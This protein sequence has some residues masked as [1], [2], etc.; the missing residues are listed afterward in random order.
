MDCWD[1]L[2]IGG[3]PP[4][5]PLLSPLQGLRPIIEAAGRPFGLDRKLRAGIAPLCTPQAAKRSA[6]YDVHMSLPGILD[7]L[8]V[9][10]ND[11]DLV[12]P[13]RGDD[14]PVGGI[15]MDRIG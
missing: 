5:T 6:S 9:S 14:E 10:G 3:T 8:A 1:L 2:P 11:R 4:Q 13:C 15:A 7:D 12:V